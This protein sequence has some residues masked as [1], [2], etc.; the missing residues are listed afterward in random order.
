MWSQGLCSHRLWSHCL[1]LDSPTNPVPL[2][3]SATARLLLSSMGI[4]R[5]L[6]C[7][8][9]RRF[10]TRTSGHLLSRLSV[11]TNTGLPSTGLLPGAHSTRHLLED[12]PVRRFGS[13]GATDRGE[14]SNWQ[15]TAQRSS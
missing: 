12:E 4:T 3:V 11:M 8:T 5:R 7:N 9:M 10:L 15:P 14:R 2:A 13:R 1:L 6:L